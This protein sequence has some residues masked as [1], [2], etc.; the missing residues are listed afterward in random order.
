MADNGGKH[1]TLLLTGFGPYP[2]A[3][4]NPT[5][6][7][8]G[9]LAQTAAPGV[10]IATAVLPT[11]WCGAAQALDQA[12]QREQ[13]GAILMFGFAPHAQSLEVETVAH[14]RALPGLTDWMGQSWP[15]RR[16]APQ[17]P[18]ALDVPLAGLVSRA[19]IASGFAVR[20]SEDAGGYVCNRALWAALYRT[21]PAPTGFIHIPWAS[22][23]AVAAGTPPK[24]VLTACEI[25]MGCTHAV[26]AV[27]RSLLGP[28]IRPGARVG[29][30]ATA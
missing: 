1:P 18:D 30:G 19:L 5:Q 29:L 20:A 22:D 14:N 23:L 11:L 2:G 8:V 26:L 27:A 13:P 10:R 21:A 17:G 16:L 25:S 24:T 6:A 4:D 3:P 15:G 28:A 9:H 7:L 12:I